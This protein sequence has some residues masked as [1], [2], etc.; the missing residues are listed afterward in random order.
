MAGSMRYGPQLIL[1]GMLCVA[2]TLPGPQPW[3]VIALLLWTGVSLMVVGAALIK[4]SP[5]VFMKQA[6]GRRHWLSVLLLLPYGLLNA[7]TFHVYRLARRAPWHEVAPGLFLGRRLTGREAAR[8]QP[9]AVVDLTCEFSEP[10]LLR[11]RRYLALPVLDTAA[12]T[13]EQMQ[14]GVDWIES[15]LA[16]GRVYVHCALGHG[17][18]ATLVAAWFLATRRCATVAEAEAQIKAV[19]S[20]IAFHPPQEAALEAFIKTLP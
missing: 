12:P 13:P 20:A 18:S 1:L 4:R 3:W 8:L 15:A 7:L 10:R 9:D 19:R 6:N 17:R 11:E 2:A 14:Q 5:M 16:D